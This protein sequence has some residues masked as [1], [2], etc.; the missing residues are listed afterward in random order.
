MC[1]S[2]THANSQG[3]PR[4]APSLCTLL[5]RGTFSWPAYAPGSSGVRPEI[6]ATGFAA[7]GGRVS[8]DL[9]GAAPTRPAFLVFG[10]DRDAS[11]AGPLPLPFAAVGLAAPCWFLVDPVATRV[12]GTDARGC[13]RAIWSL[14]FAPGLRG[15]DVHAQWIV[16]DPPANAAGFVASNGLTLTV[17]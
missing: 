5:D 6:G 2:A 15:L 10:F 13:S 8:I 4:Q 16:V 7:L 11:A 14:P 1:F 9:Y 12:L 17:Q 3:G